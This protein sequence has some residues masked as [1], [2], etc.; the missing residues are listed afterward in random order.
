MLD[1]MRH[2][3]LKMVERPMYI[4]I[5]QTDMIF[6]GVVDELASHRKSCIFN[7]NIDLLAF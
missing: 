7:H 1:E 3:D 6:E 4:D 2:Q 5:K